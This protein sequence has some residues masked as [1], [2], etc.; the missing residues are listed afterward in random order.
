[1]NRIPFSRPSIG[2]HEVEAV[3]AVLRSGWLTTGEQALAFETEFA[4]LL[5][6]PHAL[7]VNSATAGL[8]LALEAVGVRPGD[9]VIV[10]SMTFTAT[11]EVVRYLGAEVVFADLESGGLLIDPRDA[12]RRATEIVRAGHRVAAI[13]PVHLAGEPCDMLRLREVARRHGAALVEDSAHAFPSHTSAGYAGTLG[14]VGVFS[15]YANKTIT[16]GEGGMVV[17][18]RE[19]IADRVRTMRSHGIDRQAWHRYSAQALDTAA[20]APPPWYYQVVEAGYKYNMPDTAAAL[21]RVQLQRAFEL[22]KW[23]RHWAL[24][25]RDRLRSLESTGAISLPSDAEGH[26]WHLF[27]LRI[28]GM[29]RDRFITAM[30]ERHIGCSVHYIPLHRMPYW[31]DRYPEQTDGLPNTDRAF[32][33][34]V[35]IPLYP[36]LSEADHDRV[37]EAVSALL[38]DRR[39]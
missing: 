2:D 23:R 31:R 34:V 16:T 10:P 12:D 22:L 27:V 20:D 35:S 37:I 39:G 24:R 8:H 5:D 9:R 1:M 15:F 29:P 6:V 30:A 21:G 28:H 26:A 3:A 18:Q 14:D 36:D 38:E 7:A 17:T 25:Y 4:S 32:S 33:Q 11:A 13:V 19:D